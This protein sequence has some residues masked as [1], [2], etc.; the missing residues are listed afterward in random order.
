[1]YVRK[2]VPGVPTRRCVVYHV[3]FV[4]VFRMKVESP[5]LSASARLRTLKST[6]DPH[7]AQAD[8]LHHFGSVPEV[9]ASNQPAVKIRA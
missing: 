7:F 9:A 4:V 3:V 1:M 6:F 2:S 8:G 5:P